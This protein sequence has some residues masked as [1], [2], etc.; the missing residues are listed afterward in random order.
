MCVPADFYNL[1]PRAGKDAVTSAT[2]IQFFS[3]EKV[4]SLR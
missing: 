1:T 4:V 2:K 3:S